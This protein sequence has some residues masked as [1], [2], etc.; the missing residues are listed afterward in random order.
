MCAVLVQRLCISNTA[1]NSL[2]II[3]RVTSQ[4]V[5]RGGTYRLSTKA[6]KSSSCCTTNNELSTPARPRPNLSRFRCCHQLLVAAMPKGVSEVPFG[7]KKDK[8]TSNIITSRQSGLIICSLH[9]RGLICAVHELRASW[10]PVLVRTRRLFA[11]SWH[12][13]RNVIFSPRR[14][15]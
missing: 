11:R 4:W 6:H 12:I 3:S 9:F 1:D 8:A 5:G 10:N 15:Y 14:H 7:P 2:S 13:I